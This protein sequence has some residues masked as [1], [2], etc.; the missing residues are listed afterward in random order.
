MRT[1]LTPVVQP[2]SCRFCFFDRAATAIRVLYEAS[3]FELI[4]LHFQRVRTADAILL[5]FALTVNAIDAV[6]NL[7]ITLAVRRIVAREMIY[8]VVN[9]S[10]IYFCSPC[11]VTTNQ[12]KSRLH[13]DRFN[14]RNSQI[15]SPCSHCVQRNVPQS[16]SVNTTLPFSAIKVCMSMAPWKRGPS[17]GIIQ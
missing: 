2:L 10:A 4:R 14:Q 17:G 6:R 15:S 16:F 8:N 3:W 13:D 7:Q 9:P 1:I 5:V 12:R 11:D